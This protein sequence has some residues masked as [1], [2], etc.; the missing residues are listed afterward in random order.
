[1]H[2]IIELAEIYKTN[3][4]DEYIKLPLA[5]IPVR[6][7]TAYVAKGFPEWDISVYLIDYSA[8]IS[9]NPV[10]DPEITFHGIVKSN[11]VVDLKSINNIDNKFLNEMWEASKRALLRRF[12]KLS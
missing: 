3:H 1:M 7:E 2:F 12:D 10:I 6:I 4:I 8:I 5:Y 11:N 9:K